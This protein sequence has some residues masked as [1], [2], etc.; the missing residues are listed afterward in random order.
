M[1]CNASTLQIL[2]FVLSFSVTMYQSD[3]L[4]APGNIGVSSWCQVSAEPLGFYLKSLEGLV[5]SV[6]LG[7][8]TWSSLI[9]PFFHIVSLT[10]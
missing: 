6:L 1:A 8:Y 10:K 7:Q 9:P 5:L 4:G 2:S 3:S